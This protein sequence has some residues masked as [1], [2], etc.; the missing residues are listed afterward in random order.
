MTISAKFNGAYEEKRV[1][2]MY[3]KH[4]N[5]KLSAFIFFFIEFVGTYRLEKL[6]A[7]SSKEI[8]AN[9]HE[10]DYEM[11]WIILYLPSSSSSSSSDFGLCK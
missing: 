11:C 9:W 8:N 7:H 10:P 1:E 2:L 5:H 3:N 4:N 6:C